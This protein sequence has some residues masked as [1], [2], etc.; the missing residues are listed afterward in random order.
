MN[1]EKS[2]IK[3]EDILLSDLQSKIKAEIVGIKDDC[4]GEAR[5]RLLDLGFVKGTKITVQ[6]VSPLGNPIAYNLRDT[7]I[8]LRKEQ[9][10]CII[11]KTIE[12]E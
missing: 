3:H 1:P 7:L 11:I 9:A 8:A 5:R 2:N 4:K 12:D 6:N 10:D